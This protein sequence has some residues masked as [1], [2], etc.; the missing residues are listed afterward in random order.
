MS[1]CGSTVS[2]AQAGGNCGRQVAMVI[3]GDVL[4]KLVTE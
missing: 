4:S 3:R 1:S 2:N